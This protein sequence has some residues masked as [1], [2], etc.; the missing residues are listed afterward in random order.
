MRLPL[1]PIWTLG[2][3]VCLLALGFGSIS[4]LYAQQVGRIVGKVIDAESGH[5]LVGAVVEVVGT[6]LQTTSGIEG[7]YT[8]TQVPAGANSLR[9]R[10]IGYLS[11]TVTGVEV[12]AGNSVAQDLALPA[13]VVEIEELTVVAGT[14][15]GTVARAL[16]EQRSATNIVSAVTAEE[17]QKSPDGDAGQAVQRVSGVTVQDGKF[18]FVRGLGERYTTTLLNGARLPSPE[19]ER[20]V[21]PLDLFPSGLLEGITTSKT[22]TPEQGGDFS[23]AQVNLKTREFPL[24]RVINM[25][26]SG[27][28]NDAAAG[29]GVVK[30][31]KVGT[32]WLGFGGSE[33]SI[34]AAADAAGNLT[35]LPQNE[36]NA[37]IGSFRNK[38]TPYVTNGYGNS[39][40]SASMGGETPVLGRN[41]GY[42]ASF[43][44]SFAQEV[45]R[46]EERAIAAPL[47]TAGTF[48]RQN[49]YRGSTGRATVLWGGLLNLSTHLGAATRVDFNNTYT[50]S[51]D[52]EANRLAGFNEGFNENFELTRLTFTER[53]VRSHQLA[54]QHVIG[55]RHSLDA[56]VTLSQVK[57]DEP[58]R[59]DR[60]F[61]ADVDPATGRSTPLAW[62]GSSRSATKNFSFVNEDGLDGGLNYRLYLG[63]VARQRSVKA[64]IYARTT[65]RDAD[66][67]A[68]DILNANLT[69]EERAAPAEVIFD[70]TY[71]EQGR[72]FLF[73]N[74]NG[75]H[76]TAAENLVAGYLQAEL[77]ITS[78]LQ[79]LGGAR[80][81]SSR[82]DVESETI[83][84][85]LVNS[86]LD[87]TDILP[88]LSLT[89]QLSG[90]HVL[91]LS[92]TRTLS[93]PE[94][95]ELSPITYFE[96]L[97]GQRVFGNENLKRALI[98]NVDAR[99][100]WYPR[101]G[102]A[103]SVAVFAKRFDDPIERVLV[104][105]SDGN[106][107]DA[108][109]VNADRANNYGVEFELRKGLG[110]LGTTFQYFSV[111]G[112]LTLIHSEITP[113]SGGISSLTN[114]HRP[115]VGQADYVANAG[116][117]FNPANGL[118]ASLL[119][120]V[121]GKRIFEA[122][123]L[124]LPDTYEK[125]RHLVDLS[126]Q[127]PLFASTRI[128]LDAKNLLDSP[129]QMQQGSITRLRYFSG[130]VYSVGFSW[131]M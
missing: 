108:T 45:R 16:E 21:V 34:P 41:L 116:L 40:F 24:G 74:A 95:R 92:A 37:I 55:Q 26:I 23:G 84:R 10:M 25:S 105:T 1:R 104:Q 68:F 83:D 124:P 77:P 66:S 114:A 31:P 4:S 75:G 12:P 33:R 60:V 93:R 130:R 57:R 78:R 49:F 52:N 18:V 11:K 80:V 121:V 44:Y 15:R 81:E 19:P 69:A 7:R 42:V 3:L 129:F 86:R 13:R 91:R 32:E 127:F 50:R 119:Y 100:E 90:D 107:P 70:G 67:K 109:F 65:D 61:L 36:I 43:S 112:N 101:P 20:R 118:N 17:I 102:E 115:M 79:L 117:S 76:Y 51:A 82:I 27:G 39:S 88:A 120:N 47:P 131:T 28:F 106:S 29:N 103:V 122:G 87:N 63:D 59:T 71:A 22:F 38:W 35:G 58:D 62:Y 5:P 56:R 123:I 54:A 46:D 48:E 9:V 53:S 113:G 97:G 125:A 85:G 110:L 94:Y 6:S 89:Y 8:L 30:A 73:V 64:G 99:W 72:L 96:V 2:G 126:V 14:E 111:F 98:Q 128:K